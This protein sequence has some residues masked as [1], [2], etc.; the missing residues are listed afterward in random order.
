MDLTPYKLSNESD[1]R[2]A[3]ESA[4]RIVR[5]GDTPGI[6]TV[7]INDF[8][9]CGGHADQVSDFLAAFRNYSPVEHWEPPPRPRTLIDAA[10]AMLRNVQPSPAARNKELRALAA[11]TSQKAI[12]NRLERMNPALRHHLET[13]MTMRGRGLADACHWI[14]DD[15]RARSTHQFTHIE[16]M[17]VFEFIARHQRVTVFQDGEF[18]KGLKQLR[19]DCRAR[20]IE[21]EL[22]HRKIP[23]QEHVTET[24]IKNLLISARN[25]VFGTDKPTLEAV[26]KM[27]ELPLEDAQKMMAAWGLDSGEIQ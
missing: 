13:I 5:R 20:A 9:Q 6:E 25:A 26:V 19:S 1:F 27:Y 22:D 12:Q 16:V 4:A 15:T 18:A 2:N 3:V 7:L 11:M 10:M 23:A 24:H 17:L 21:E 14:A 8:I